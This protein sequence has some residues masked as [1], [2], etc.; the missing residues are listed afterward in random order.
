M[1]C[2]WALGALL[3]LIGLPLKVIQWVV[4]PLIGALGLFLSIIPLKMI[5]GKDFG[6]F[7]LVLVAKNRP[8]DRSQT[9]KF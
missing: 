7:R 6:E 5:L 2:C 9:L 8:H 4:A 3:G 1:I